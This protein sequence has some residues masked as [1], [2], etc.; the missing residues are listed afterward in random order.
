MFTASMRRAAALPAAALPAAVAAATSLALVAGCSSS[1]GADNAGATAAGGVVVQ[2]EL[3][4]DGCVPSP[5]SVSAGLVTFKV[6]NKDAAAVSE[7]ELL[8]GGSIL[9]EK[10]NLTPGLSGS[11]SLR[12][13]PGDYVMSC[14][15][16]KTDHAEFTVTGGDSS[17]A[18]DPSASALAEQA[19]Q[20]YHDYVVDQVSQLLTAA[21][22][23]TTAV[24]AG[25]IAGAKAAYGPA[26]THYES[27]EPVAESFGDLDPSIDAREND[28]DDLTTWTGFHRIEKALWQDTTLAGMAPMADRLTTDLTKLQTLVEQQTYQPA[29]IANGCVELLDEVAKSKVTGEDDRYSHT[30]LF[31]F[32][33]NVLGAQEGFTALKPLLRSSD[34]DLA[35]TIDARFADVLSALAKYKQGDG[36]V[37]YSTVSDQDRR[38]LAQKVDAL[39]EPLS[40]VAARVG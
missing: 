21:G 11:F 28:V 20:K 29:Q 23:F 38:V 12:L 25:D 31:D 18:P 17:T 5:N 7:A 33:A 19:G 37:D 40:Q 8:S 24:K 27:I 26:R 4:S 39:A 16:A 15:N 36:W 1:D 32:E 10:E 34:P 13:K 9:G 3:T 2:V 6:K 35:D 22:K 14:P 30:D